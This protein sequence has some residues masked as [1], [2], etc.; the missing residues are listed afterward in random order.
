MM[1]WPFQGKAPLPESFP[2]GQYKLDGS[3]EGLVGLIEFS[4]NEYAAIGRQFVGEKDYNALP[5]T[6]LGRPWEVMVQAVR[7]RICAIA[8]YLL[9]ADSRD[10]DRIVMETFQYCV[11]QLGKPA[12]RKA[13]F[14]LWRVSDGSVI[15]KTEET[16]DGLRIGLFLTSSSMPNLQRL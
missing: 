12:E 11:E 15:L 3:I 1:R 14:F 4:P 7:G 2:V 6:F 9:L 13:D 16:A 10:A 8:P 5:I